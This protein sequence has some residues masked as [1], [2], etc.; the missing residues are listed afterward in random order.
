MGLDWKEYQ[1]AAKKKWVSK[2]PPNGKET[3]NF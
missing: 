3:Y 2:I 1:H